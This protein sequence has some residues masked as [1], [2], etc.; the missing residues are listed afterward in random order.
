MGRDKGG[1]KREEREGS[2]DIYENFKKEN[3]ETSASIPILNFYFVPSLW[4]LESLLSSVITCS[5][6]IIVIII[7]I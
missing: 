7:S 4:P 6:D 1:I 5:V 3:K 2:K